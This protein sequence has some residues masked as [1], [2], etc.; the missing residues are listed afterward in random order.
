MDRI[1][2]GDS[3]GGVSLSESRMEAVFSNFDESFDAEVKTLKIGPE[4]MCLTDREIDILRMA[5]HVG[6]TNNLLEDLTEYWELH[7]ADCVGKPA[8]LSDADWLSLSVLQHLG[9]LPCDRSRL[10]EPLQ[11]LK[12]VDKTDVLRTVVKSLG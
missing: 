12:S 6:D 11:A 3:I 4:R 2:L 10:A 1:L 8:S 9:L 5:C 7:G